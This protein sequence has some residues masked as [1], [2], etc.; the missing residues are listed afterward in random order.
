MTRGAKKGESCFSV[1]WPFLAF[2]GG[3]KKRCFFVFFRVFR[4]FP[5]FSQKSG[6]FGFFSE[7]SEKLV[8]KLLF[9]VKK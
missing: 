2:L 1:F 8:V 6:F 9:F 7:N 4:V 3:V 5:V